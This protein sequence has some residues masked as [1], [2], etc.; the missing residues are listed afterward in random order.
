MCVTHVRTYVFPNGRKEVVESPEYCRRSTGSRFCNQHR[1]REYPEQLIASSSSAMGSPS[2]VDDVT[3]PSS[4]SFPPTPV[5]ATSGARLELRQP[6][7]VTA[8]VSSK[9]KEKAKRSINF[10]DLRTDLSK[11]KYLSSSRRPEERTTRARFADEESESTVRP[12]TPSRR[13]RGDQPSPS[14]LRSPA[15]AGIPSPRS[16]RTPPTEVHQPNPPSSSQGETAWPRAP[17]PGLR[18]DTDTDPADISRPSS[19]GATVG[20]DADVFT[21][22]DARAQAREETQRQERERRRLEDER[23]RRFRQQQRQQQEEDD[24]RFAEQFEKQFHLNDQRRARQAA[25]NENRERAEDEYSLREYE[26]INGREAL[27]EAQRRRLEEEDR[28]RRIHE[29]LSRER[30]EQAHA[31]RVAQELREDRQRR[32]DAARREAEEERR[33]PTYSRRRHEFERR[34]DSGLQEA[35]AQMARQNEESD[36]TSIQREIQRLTNEIEYDRETRRQRERGDNLAAERRRI[37]E[38][39]AEVALMEERDREIARTEQELRELERGGSRSQRS[40]WYGSPPYYPPSGYVGAGESYTSPTTPTSLLGRRPSSGGSGSA[41]MQVRSPAEDINYRRRRGEEVLRQERAFAN[42]R[43]SAL[44]MQR[45]VN[46]EGAYLSGGRGL[47]RRNTVGGGGR[48]RGT[49][50]RG[51]RRFYPA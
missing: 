36:L 21:R 9:G 40:S 29:Q 27:R 24:R 8:S 18:R 13:G 46:D 43:D 30:E 15:P 22:A 17:T 45:A 5:S 38:L 44:E 35:V 7:G 20:P 42:A 47:N 2:L 25:S 51:Q 11:N 31:E 32:S 39:E 6:S 1:R 16:R 23:V 37:E 14:I 26:R 34:R 28:L 4:G 12:D 10:S 3:T 33:D 48:A 19:T 50:Y 41:V 49:A